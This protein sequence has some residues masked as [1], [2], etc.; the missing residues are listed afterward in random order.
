MK[1]KPVIFLLL[2]FLPGILPVT[3]FAQMDS[4]GGSECPISYSFKKNNGGGKCG[5]NALVAV[6]FNPM[7]LPGNIPVLTGIYYKG[8][9]L[10]N[11]LPVE[12][13]LVTRGRDINISYCLSERGSQKGS[14]SN[15]SPA[16]KLVL[17][18][19]YRD[20]TTCRTHNAN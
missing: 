10:V 19:T 13:Y 4:G 2:F 3:A 5:G 11:K 17:E 15:I 9:P 8:Q 12:G 20:G 18:F 16:G 6:I 14:F 1:T 7:P